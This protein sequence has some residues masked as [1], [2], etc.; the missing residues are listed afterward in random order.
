MKSFERFDSVLSADHS[1]DSW[2]DDGLMYA[3]GIIRQFDDDD[4]AALRSIWTL[5]SEQWQVKL[6]DVMIVLSGDLA[7]SL[8]IDILRRGCVSAAQRAAA[9]MADIIPSE[10]RPDSNLLAR[11][12][13]LRDASSSKFDRD[14]ISALLR[15]YEG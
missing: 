8:V 15:R 2:S 5:R 13:A 3:E 10:W 12:T 4:W 14:D 7:F 11:I 9:D 1:V 6:V